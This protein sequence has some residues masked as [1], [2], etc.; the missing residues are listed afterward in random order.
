MKKFEEIRRY[1]PVLRPAKLKIYHIYSNTIYDSFDEFFYS[2]TFKDAFYECLNCSYNASD[3]IDIS[4][5]EK[6]D[7]YKSVAEDTIANL[8]DDQNI[9]IVI[10]KENDF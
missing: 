10:E 9:F 6:M 7:M 8:V 1:T 5:D 3:F 4:P 2:E